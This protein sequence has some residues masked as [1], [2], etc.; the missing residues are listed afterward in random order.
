[1]KMLGGSEC[2]TPDINP[3]LMDPR[4]YLMGFHKRNLQKKEASKQRREEREKQERQE[5]RREVPSHLHHAHVLA[6]ECFRIG[7]CW[8]KGRWRTQRR[9]K[10]HMV[11]RMVSQCVGANIFFCCY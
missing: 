3:M 5:M 4:D 8:Q 1:M 2:R 6:H 9:W 11:R 7:K 10:R